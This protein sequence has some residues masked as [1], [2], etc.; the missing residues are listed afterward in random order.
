M[1]TFDKRG[2]PIIEAEARVPYELAVGPTWHRFYEGFK[3]EKIFGTRCSQCD[4]VL[5]PARS[6][7][8]R[9]FVDMD[10]WVEVSQ[11]GAVISWVI[12]NYEYFGMPTKPP[13]INAAVL[14]DGTDCGFMH[15]MGGVDLS[16]LDRVGE[17]VKTG[18]K[19]RAVWRKEKTGCI[20]D[21]KYFEPK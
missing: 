13:F 20:M 7:C 15:L 17:N 14:L 18:M 3:K 12:T 9:C 4:R 11:E 19:V 21:I 8:S 10:E 6:F 5:V 16:D 1:I 2:N